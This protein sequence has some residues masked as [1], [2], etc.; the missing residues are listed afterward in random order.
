MIKLLCFIFI[1][2]LL[3]AQKYAAD[4]LNLDY[5][6]KTLASGNTFFVNQGDL[7][8]VRWFPADY[9]Y[10]KERKIYGTFIS[11]YDGLLEQMHVGYSQPLFGGYNITAN[12]NYSGVT[13]I[14]TYGKLILETDRTP[15][16]KEPSGFFDNQN[17]IVSTTFSK[18]YDEQLDLGWDYFKLPIKFPVAVNVNYLH[19][20][21]YDL[22]ANAF[23]ID[24]SFGASFNLGT[25]LK[26]EGLGDFS[27]FIN[28]VNLAGSKLAWDVVEGESGSTTE[29]FE[30]ISSNTIWGFNFTQP[31][32]DIKIDFGIGM[33][34]QS[35]YSSFAYGLTFIYDKQVELRF[36]FDNDDVAFG[37]GVEFNGIE[38]FA[39]MKPNHDLGK[40]LNMDIV[41]GF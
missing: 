24:L 26:T 25:L 27:T 19:S 34:F 9:S 37:L 23:T 16:Q 22:N 14:P 4:F 13:D 38:L 11:K 10:N 36:G 5:G 31:A 2:S 7:A 8:A 41:Y 12:I 18:L 21:L 39:S 28:L 35:L 32:K 40:S 29:S 30:K 3:S 1:L 20:V 6:A 33:Q 15:T 17:F